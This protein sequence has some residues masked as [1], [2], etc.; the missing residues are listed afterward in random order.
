[1]ESVSRKRG[2]RKSRLIF[3]CIFLLASV[4]TTINTEIRVFSFTPEGLP[5]S[6][7]A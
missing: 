6:G 1:M 2:F 3:G 7:D 4:M 5:S